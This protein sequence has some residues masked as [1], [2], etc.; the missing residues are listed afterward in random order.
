M[1]SLVD[2]IYDEWCENKSITNQDLNI[3]LFM[4]NFNNDKQKEELN[5][6]ITDCK[7]DIN[8]I[9]IINTYKVCVHNGSSRF[10]TWEDEESRTCEYCKYLVYSNLINILDEINTT[11]HSGG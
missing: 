8:K 10:L 9:D 11:I 5:K 3:S 4:F 1:K 2:K 7:E 6:F